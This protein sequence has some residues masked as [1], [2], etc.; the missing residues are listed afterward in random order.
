MKRFL[1]LVSLLVATTAVAEKKS[2]KKK[3]SKKRAATTTATAT[4][5]EDRSDGCGLGWQVTKKKTLSAT[6]T[7]ATTNGFVPPTLGMTSGTIGCDQHGF[8]QNDRESLTYVA[9]NFDAIKLEMAQGQGHKLAGLAETMGCSANVAAFG[10]VVQQNYGRIVR[11]Q[12]AAPADVLVNLKAVT[13]EKLAS[14]C[15]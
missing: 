6:S 2:S 9:T 1:F 13:K 5:G 4:T 10:A 15:G 11:S 14:V 7:R 3:G 8:V 12:A